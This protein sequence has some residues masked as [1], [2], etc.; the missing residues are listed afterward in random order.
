MWL[1]I[2]GPPP[3][4]RLWSQRRFRA[5][6]VYALNLYQRWACRVF[7]LIYIYLLSHLHQF[8]TLDCHCQL[9]AWLTCTH[10]TA[11]DQVGILARRKSFHILQFTSFLCWLCQLCNNAATLRLSAGE[12]M[13][14]AMGDVDGKP[15]G[16]FVLLD[17]DFKVS[18][19]SLILLS[20]SALIEL[21]P[22]ARHIS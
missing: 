4:P 18:G 16:G 21:A 19:P 5:R 22:N 10:R 11:W 12:I 15:K 7:S 6:Q 14:S 13:V 1:Q 17:E 9:Q 2:Q 8:L 20:P 3:W